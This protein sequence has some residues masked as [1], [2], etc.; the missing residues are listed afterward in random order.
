MYGVCKICGCTDN[1]PCSNP[2]HGN[3]WWVDATHTL[4]SHCA[5]E[6]IATDPQ[7]QHCINSEAE[8]V[9]DNARCYTCLNFLVDEDGEYC[10]RTGEAIPLGGY[11]CVDYWLNE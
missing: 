2:V 6:T 9:P 5:D 10:D 4:C 8:S 1:N 11:A 7:T 3:C